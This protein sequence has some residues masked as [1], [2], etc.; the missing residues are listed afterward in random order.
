[1]RGYCAG[2]LY[3][4]HNVYRK[5]WKA[6]VRNYN[7]RGSKNEMN[8]K[9]LNFS[10]INKRSVG[11]YHHLSDERVSSWLLS[12][13]VIGMCITSST[14]MRLNKVCCHLTSVDGKSR[15]RT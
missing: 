12:L 10:E 14:E 13:L 9:V 5:K 1:M 3:A 4:W 11:K 2:K 6:K 7:L 8:L 15:P